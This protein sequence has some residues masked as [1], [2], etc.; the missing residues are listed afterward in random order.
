MTTCC[1]ARSPARNA[2]PTARLGPS[3]TTNARHPPPAPRRCP[4]ASARK[5]RTP[6]AQAAPL[7][8]AKP[9]SP[10]PRGCARRPPPVSLLPLPPPMP[11]PSSPPP[12]R[13]HRRRCRCHYRCL[14]CDWFVWHASSPPPRPPRRL[15]GDNH[16]FGR[17]DADTS[18]KTSCSALARPM[19]FHM[20]TWRKSFKKRTKW[21]LNV[22]EGA[23]HS[24]PPDPPP[25]PPRR[26]GLSTNPALGGVAAVPRESTRG[27]RKR[28][29]RT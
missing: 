24:A 1:S 19:K 11:P 17:E 12:H 20:Y 22:M 26:P 21:R 16:A 4:P 27:D 3:P 13:C 25:Q 5:K 28:R 23:T 15:L 9:P 6:G 14:C 8:I 2:W 18:Q 29:R 10:H 7:G